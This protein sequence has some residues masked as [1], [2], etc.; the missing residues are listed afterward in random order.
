MNDNALG[1]SIAQTP[2]QSRSSIVITIVGW[3]VC[4]RHMNNVFCIHYFMRHGIS[5]LDRRYLTAHGVCV[6]CFCQTAYVRL[7]SLNLTTYEPFYF[8]MHF[9]SR[10][11]SFSGMSL[12]LCLCDVSCMCTSLHPATYDEC[13]CAT[14]TT[15]CTTN[16]NAKSVLSST[17]QRA[18]FHLLSYERTQS[19]T[20]RL[21]DEQ[22][23]D[24]VV[25][26]PQVFVLAPCTSVCMYIRCNVCR[27]YAYCSTRNGWCVCLS[28]KCLFG[29]R[30]RM[31]CCHMHNVF[32]DAYAQTHKFL[33]SSKEWF[34]TVNISHSTHTSNAKNRYFHIP[35]YDNV[36]QKYE[37]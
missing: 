4:P 13:A 10:L 21:D 9:L 6:C 11:T 7:W 18:Y 12:S 3:I 34:F 17:L 1:L 36:R 28:Q 30:W 23:T 22:K 32:C 14:V 25:Y 8:Y 27:V 37:K 16:M 29:M 24:S 35:H 33:I 15:P 19:A 2:P 20:G 5:S 31:L 26:V